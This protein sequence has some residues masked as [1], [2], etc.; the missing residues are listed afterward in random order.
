MKPGKET[1]ALD[2]TDIKHV[3]GFLSSLS[4]NL[5]TLA[6]IGHMQTHIQC[7]LFPKTFNDIP[8]KSYLPPIYQSREYAA[9]LLLYY[10]F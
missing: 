2:L 6:L 5:I 7:C 4:V 10:H 8:A 1:L 3:Y 9:S